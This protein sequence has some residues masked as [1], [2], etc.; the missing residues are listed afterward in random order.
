MAMVAALLDISS[1]RVVCAQACLAPDSV[2]EFCNVN[3]IRNTK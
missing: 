1:I 2:I 3:T